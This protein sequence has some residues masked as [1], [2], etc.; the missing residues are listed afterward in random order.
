MLW[1]TSVGHE[2]HS[3]VVEYWTIEVLDGE[4]SALRWRDAYGE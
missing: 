3:A 4:L 2:A 1:L